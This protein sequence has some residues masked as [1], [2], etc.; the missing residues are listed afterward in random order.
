VLGLVAY[1][2]LNLGIPLGLLGVLDMDAGG[3]QLL[4]PGGLFE[5]VVLPTWLIAKGS[6][7]PSPQEFASPALASTG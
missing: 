7:T 1:A 6:R 3:G 5:T 2:C 4:V